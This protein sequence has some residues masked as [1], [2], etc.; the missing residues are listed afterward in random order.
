MRTGAPDLD[1]VEDLIAADADGLLPVAA[2]GGA[3]VRAVAETMREGVFEPLA[4]LR[5][6][7]VVVVCG[8]TG[9]ARAAAALVSAILATH[10]DVPIVSATALPGWIGP[11]DVVV[12]AG[13]DAGDMVLADAAARALRRRAEVVVAAPIE[14]P[15]QDALGGNGINA[16]PRLRVDPRF[17]FA[18]YVAVLLAVFMSLTQVRLTGGVPQLSDMADALDADAAANHSSHETF[19]N[20]AK[21]LAARLIER[22]V[23]WTGDGAAASVVAA[24]NAKSLLAIAGIVS[25]TGDLAEIARVTHDVW[26]AR[27]PEIDPIFYD[28]EIDGPAGELPPRVFVASTGARDWY[29]RQRVAAIP[30][31]EVIVGDEDLSAAQARSRTVPVAADT[32]RIDGPADVTSFLM[33]ILRVEMAA[34]YLRLTGA[35]GR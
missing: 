30:D 32:D 10:V 29:T 35:G 14:G 17:R 4:T 9:T 13:D 24:Q 8:T 25:A 33:L 19:R 22:P 3:Q 2:L 20:R 34:V 31:A 5:P 7:S 12:V 15:L 27:R 21:S 11:L 26:A 6:R 16:S 28:P 1:D 18:G 23:V